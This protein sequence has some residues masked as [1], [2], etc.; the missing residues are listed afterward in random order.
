MALVILLN[1]AETGKRL[2]FVCS[3]LPRIAIREVK[4]TSVRMPAISPSSGLTKL[5]VIR[6]FDER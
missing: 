3:Q 5:S 1:D 6:I 2:V 4:V